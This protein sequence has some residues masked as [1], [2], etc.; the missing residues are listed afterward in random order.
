M[1]RDAVWEG[2][3][4]GVMTETSELLARAERRITQARTSTTT[5]VPRGAITLDLPDEVRTEP[6]DHALADLLEELRSRI[7]EL[8]AELASIRKSHPERCPYTGRKHFGEIEHPE[9]G[10]VPV[11]GGPFDSYTIPSLDRSEGELRCY[12]YD[13]DDGCWEDGTVGTGLYVYD[14]QRLTDAIA[15]TGL[16]DLQKDVVHNAIAKALAGGEVSHGDQS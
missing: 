3:E 6:G 9:L 14:E 16:A 2:T 1:E 10:L 15:A 4:D 5:T 13:H 11:Y 8:E 7:E 12:H